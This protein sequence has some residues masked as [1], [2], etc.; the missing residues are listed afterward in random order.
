MLAWGLRPCKWKCGW[1]VNVSEDAQCLHKHIWRVGVVGESCWCGNLG[2]L[3]WHPVST[4]NL[5][6]VAPHGSP[7]V[8]A[9]VPDVQRPSFDVIHTGAYVVS[10]LVEAA[11]GC[12]L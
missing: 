10:S 1:I 8:F 2:A 6:E 12:L 7:Q 11:E 5:R 4:S 9:L 3:G